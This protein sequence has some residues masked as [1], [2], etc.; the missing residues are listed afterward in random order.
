MFIPG[1]ELFT[2]SREASEKILTVSNRHDTIKY[3]HIFPFRLPNISTALSF[4]HLYSVPSIRFRFITI[5]THPSYAWFRHVF[6]TDIKILCQ[7][8]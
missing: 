3:H 4:K 2:V 1:M 7:P 8:A 5:R 6:P